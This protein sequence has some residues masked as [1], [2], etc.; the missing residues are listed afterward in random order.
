MK[1]QRPTRPQERAPR[2]RVAQAH[3]DPLADDRPS[4]RATRIVWTALGFSLAGSLAFLGWA[5]QRERELRH[6]A[7]ETPATA[8]PSASVRVVES[9]EPA[10]RDAT[11]AFVLGPDGATQWGWALDGGILDAL[12]DA[13]GKCLPANEQREGA[14][15]RV[16][17]RAE[18]SEGNVVRY[19]RIVALE[20]QAPGALPARFY[21]FDAGR[22]G[23]V[24]D[25]RG[26]RSCGV[27]WQAPL[28]ELRRTSPFNPKRMHPILHRLMPHQG[29]DYG[30]AL[31]TPV[32]ASYR[33]VVDW[34]GPHGS[35]G[36]WVT[37]VHPDG[38]ET[39]YAH[40][41]KFAR[42][43]KRGDHVH[44]HQIIGFVGSTGRST[45]PHLHWSARKD[46]AYFD[47][48][49]LLGKVGPGVPESLRAAFLA[50]KAELDRRLDGIPPPGPKPATSG[51]AAPP[52]R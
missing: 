11:G 32:Y 47:A 43:I 40:L 19:T 35:H 6:G 17:A 10:P 7:V 46:G 29:T 4:T 28:A 30:A 16:V 3:W 50:A 23:E 14:V 2:L 26:A 20:Y 13:V 49:T 18:R 39:G 8:D 27:G 36:N 38:V 34:V 5:V 52:R 48:E 25:G 22:G 51:P 21:G 45:G 15:V 41:S 44:A 37:V 1:R 33:G 12:D 42:G 24:F 31:G 9:S